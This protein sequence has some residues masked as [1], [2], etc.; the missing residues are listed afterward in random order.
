M[1]PLGGEPP[2]NPP[3][4]PFVA[5]PAAGL[6]PVAGH[7]PEAAPGAV[8]FNIG[9][10]GVSSTFVYTPNGNAPMR[11]SQW[12]AND[13]SRTE[14]KIPSWAIVLA[15]VFALACL[16]GLLFLLVKER[17]T[18]GYVEVRVSSGTLMHATQIPVS[19]PNQVAYTRQLVAQ[20][21][22]IAAAA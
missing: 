22:A 14:E 18:T 7:V 1:E 16:L 15:I 5:P 21:Q 20:A 19:D 4:P 8:M 2:P 12:F 6:P 10:I 17:Q 11:G 3:P 9:D 13:M